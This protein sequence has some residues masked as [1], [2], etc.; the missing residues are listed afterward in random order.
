MRPAVVTGT[1]IFVENVWHSAM[2]IHFGK[3]KRF[4]NSCI[5]RKMHFLV[6]VHM[7]EYLNICISYWITVYEVQAKRVV[8]VKLIIE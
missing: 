2:R 6:P 1:G 5:S 8:A 4:L 3:K 7:Y